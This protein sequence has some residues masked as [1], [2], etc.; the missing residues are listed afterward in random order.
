[1]RKASSF[2]DVTKSLPLKGR[3]MRT[4]WLMAGGV[5]SVRLGETVTPVLL[6]SCVVFVVVLTLTVKLELKQAA[7]PPVE[8]KPF[9]HG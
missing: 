6:M 5:A 7:F 3:L 9:G 4:D 2:L 8:E 1:M